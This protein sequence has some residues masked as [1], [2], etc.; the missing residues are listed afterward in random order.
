MAYI[1]NYCKDIKSNIILL[2]TA[3]QNHHDPSHTIVVMNYH[4][5]YAFLILRVGAY[6]QTHTHTHTHHDNQ[7]IM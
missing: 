1:D 3:I 2:C 5:P 7:I 4:I 6:Y